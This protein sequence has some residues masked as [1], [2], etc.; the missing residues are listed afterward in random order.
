MA[1]EGRA[2]SV[3]LPAMSE[4]SSAVGVV[5]AAARTER[6]RGGRRQNQVSKTKRRDS[7]ET[8]STDLRASGWSAEKR[9]ELIS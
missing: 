7:E 8:K 6:E 4:I 1:K 5:T 2:L 9:I 3:R